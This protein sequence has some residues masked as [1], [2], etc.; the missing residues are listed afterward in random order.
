[1][2]RNASCTGM[3]DLVLNFNHFALRSRARYAQRRY[4]VD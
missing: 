4:T 2:F 3:P 1:M